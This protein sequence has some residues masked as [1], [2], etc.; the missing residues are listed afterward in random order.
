MKMEIWKKDAGPTRKAIA[1]PSLGWK[2]GSS[3]QLGSPEGP[4][5]SLNLNGYEFPNEELGPTEDNPADDFDRGRF[6]VV[7]V[8][9]KTQTGDWRATAPEMTTTELERLVSWLE[10]VSNR[11][12]SGIGVYFTERDLEFTIDENLGRLN[13]HL[14]RDFLPPWI[15]SEKSLTMSFPI[16]QANLRE[17]VS[18]LRSQLA[19]FPGRPPLWDQTG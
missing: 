4:S 9:F 15:E 19:R 14:L 7:S 6:L 8:S 12:P 3:M 2:S 1:R 17:A 18:S 10:S 5:F 16:D 11:Q 13:V